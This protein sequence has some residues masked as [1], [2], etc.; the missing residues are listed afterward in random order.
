MGYEYF[1]IPYLTAL[2][3]EGGWDRDPTSEHTYSIVRAHYAVRERQLNEPSKGGDVVGVS[4][5]LKGATQKI[6][7]SKEYEYTEVKMRQS[8]Q[9]SLVEQETIT[10]ITS[11]IGASL[12][13]GIA[14]LSGDLKSSIRTQLKESFKNTFTVQ[15]TE[16]AKEK[17]VKTLEYMVDPAQFGANARLVT[18]K[19]YKRHA[20]DL[21]LVFV[22][23]LLVEYRRPPFGVRLKRS[24]RPTA[25]GGFHPNIVKLDWP[26]VSMLF[27]RQVPD[28]LLL[29][30]EK[31]YVIEVEDPFEI[32]IQELTAT[33]SFPVKLPPKP[34]L[35]DVSEQVFP[36]KRWA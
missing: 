19:A 31:D 3:K 6:T 1:T 25:K 21:Y 30:P 24:K 8:V 32:T 14:K 22:D 12:G 27:W 33:K 29:V 15:I 10:E 35:Y 9:E 5:S 13:A 20:L 23:Y 7:D 34:S 36:L 17:K 18:A 28:S 11:S 2:N 26:L 16:S 4:T